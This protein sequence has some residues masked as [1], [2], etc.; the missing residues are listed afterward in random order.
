[1]IVQD[2]GFALLRGG[3]PALLRNRRAVR[4]SLHHDRRWYGYWASSLFG[5][6]L[7]PRYYF[8]I[9]DGDTLVLDDGLPLLAACQVRLHCD[10]PAPQSRPRGQDFLRVREACP[11]APSSD[12]TFSATDPACRSGVPDL[13]S[14]QLD[15]SHA[16]L[17]KC[18][19]ESQSFKHCE[20]I[21]AMRAAS[22]SLAL[23]GSGSDWA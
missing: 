3:K 14:L 9:R 7:M 6:S 23:F 2:I 1:M 17:V 19:P 22:L 21:A 16:C 8:H 13:P 5:S 15:R 18:V 11:M 12:H 4:D 20:Y 10:A